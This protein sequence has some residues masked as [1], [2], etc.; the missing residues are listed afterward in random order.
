M[1][2]KINELFIHCSATKPEWMDN[3]TV[4]DKL[5]EIDN[6][7]K[8]RGWKGFGYHYLIDRDG[9]VATGRPLEEVGAHVSGHNTNSIGVCIVG[10][11]GSNADDN[12]ENNFTQA[13]L[14]SLYEL[15]SELSQRFP[16]A[17]VRG[18]NE[19]ANK[20]CP[21]F[22]VKAWWARR[23]ERE[24]T[25]I[26]HSKT[27]QAANAGLASV[28]LGAGVTAASDPKGTIDAVGGLNP[29]VQIIGALTLL[30]AVVAFIA[31]KYF[32][33]KDWDA[34]WR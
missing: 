4:E 19:V 23:G 27:N 31:V 33:K 34:G 11:F 24:R 3:F 17:K 30:L 25:S 16:N 28:V 26:T 18:H 1:V 6:W 32:R 12:P 20:A 9:S 29:T 14:D 15:V 7:H 2:R 22:N 21:G 10:G 5:Q 8:A 13:Q